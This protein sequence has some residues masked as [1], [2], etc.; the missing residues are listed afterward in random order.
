M[1]DPHAEQVAHRQ[2]VGD[3]RKIVA[4]REAQEGF[5]R[6][7]YVVAKLA[8]RGVVL[9]VEPADGGDEAIRQHQDRRAMEMRD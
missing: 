1:R 7:S 6:T 5:E 9:H 2:L 3:L 4:V 8:D